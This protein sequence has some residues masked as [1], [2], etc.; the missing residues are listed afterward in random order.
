MARLES[1][2]TF[3]RIAEKVEQVWNRDKRG[4]KMDWIGMEAMLR[5]VVRAYRGSERPGGEAAII[6][7]RLVDDVIAAYTLRGNELPQERAPNV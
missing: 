6:A 3:A 1:D 4:L 7:M 5:E 2:E